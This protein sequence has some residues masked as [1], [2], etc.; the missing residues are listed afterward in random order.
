MLTLAQK[1]KIRGMLADKQSA[2]TIAEEFGITEADVQALSKPKA[3][4][5][6][7]RA[8]VPLASAGSLRECHGPAAR[9]GDLQGPNHRLGAARARHASPWRPAPLGPLS[10]LPKPLA[11][12]Q[13]AVPSRSVWRAGAERVHALR[14]RAT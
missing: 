13:A 2:K 8:V 3:V 9:T 4:R 1:N 6:D 11:P 12:P 14:W 7:P 10:A 5:A